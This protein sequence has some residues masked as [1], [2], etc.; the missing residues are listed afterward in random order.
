M[1]QSELPS[2]DHELDQDS[3]NTETNV[4]KAKLMQPGDKIDMQKVLKL[5]D[6]FE[7]LSLDEQKLAMH[8]QIIRVYLYMRDKIRNE[9]LMRES[10]KNNL[11]SSHDQS[12]FFVE[13]N[14]LADED[15]FQ[16]EQ[17]DAFVLEM[18]SFLII[19]YIKQAIGVII[20][21]KLEDFNQEANLTATRIMQDS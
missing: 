4:I 16:V 6:Q 14:L 20:D 21:F 10:S 5:Q 12:K 9:C 13:N 11:N 17:E 1:M 7:K 2:P 3:D 19:E 8:R 15:P 18:D